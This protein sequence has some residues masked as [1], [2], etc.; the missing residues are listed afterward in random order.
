M[1]R[2]TLHIL[3]EDPDP[4]LAGVLEEQLAAGCEVELAL[5][6]GAGGWTPP[7]GCR[8]HRLDPAARTEDAATL[9]DLLYASHNTLTW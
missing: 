5:L 9:L 2:R 4:R 7:A 3:H 8:V 6:P 1:A